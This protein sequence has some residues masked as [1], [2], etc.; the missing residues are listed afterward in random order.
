[1][2]ELPISQRRGFEFSELEL[3]KLAILMVQAPIQQTS[4]TI[5]QF[6]QGKLEIDVLGKDYDLYLHPACILH[7]YCGHDWTII[8]P[9]DICATN[10]VIG[11]LH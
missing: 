10:T 4:P 5:T 3:N 2:E 1:M 7:Q 11:V 9:F 6:L 8:F